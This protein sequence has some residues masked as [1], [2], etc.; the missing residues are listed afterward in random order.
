M[1]NRNQLKKIF[2]GLKEERKGAE[3]KKEED[4]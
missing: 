1:N 4:R 3:K 2:N